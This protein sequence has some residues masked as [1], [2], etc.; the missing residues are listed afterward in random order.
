MEKE[1]ENP[2]PEKSSSFNSATK[3]VDVNGPPPPDSDP[4]AVDPKPDATEND[5]GRVE[6]DTEPPPEPEL[7]FPQASE[8]IDAFL[9]NLAAADDKSSPMEVPGCVEKFCSMVDSMIA[10]YDS[11]DS[12]AKLGQV[13]EEDS[14]LLEALSRLSKLTEALRDVPSAE[15]AASSVNRASSVVQRAMAYFEEEF[16]ALLEDSRETRDTKS[17]SHSDPKTTKTSKQSSFN[18]NQ[19]SDRCVLPE[20]ETPGREEEFPVYSTEVVSSLNRIATAMVSAGYETECCQVYSVAR[21]NAFRDALNKLG[22]ER[23]SIDDVQKMPWDSVEG[24]IATWIKVVKQCAGVLFSGEKK[25]CETVFSDVDASISQSLFGNLA[26]AVVVHLLNFAEAVSLTKR[27][28][29][30]LFKFLDMYEA[31]RDVVPAI[32]CDSDFSDDCAHELKSET[33]AAGFRLGEA[34]VG[35]FCDLE[36]SIRSDTGKTPVASG[37]VHPL[38]RYTMN[39]LK[40]ACEY[41]DTLEQIFLQHQRVDGSD[42]SESE[43]EPAA[44]KP[45]QSD[46]QRQHHP[47]K[48]SKPSPFSVQLI[49]VMDLLDSNLESKSKLYK[50]PALRNIFLMNNGRYILQKIKG[51]GEIHEVMG[52]TWCRKRSSDLRQYHKNYQRETWGRVL[53]CLRDE[54]LHGPNG[55]FIK[56]ALKERFKSFNAIFE[57]IHRTQS[58]WVVSDEQLQSELRVSI[59]AVVIPAYRSFLGRFQQQLDPGRQTEKY[60]KLQPEDIETAIEELF[61]G[62]PTSMGRRR[63]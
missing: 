1:K 12:P 36:N 46:Q 59:S 17:S 51:S 47:P 28:A 3:T 33:T 63:A 10:K 13:A 50:D 55:K 62:N 26:R 44:G 45:N 15:A 54:G 2:P 11:G 37:A 41:K 43:T 40:Y 61:D 6:G 19:D 27:S 57:E 16:R 58:T 20:P 48:P 24:E 21:R 23:I 38:T 14:S 34:S 29:E 9:A 5:Q 18:R 8:E 35:I 60:I 22:L 52:D 42:E 39:Y 32:A 7:T 31:L 25:F 49:A 56:P 4:P 53:G 30:K